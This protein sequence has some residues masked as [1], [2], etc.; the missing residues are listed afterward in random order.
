VDWLPARFAWV[1]AALSF[2]T[3][4][5]SLWSALAGHQKRATD[6]ADLHFRWN[7]LA[8]RY[9]ELWDEMYDPKA[10]T[11]LRQ[12]KGIAAEISKSDAAFPNDAERMGKWQTL[13][14]AQHQTA[15]TA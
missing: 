1:R 12:L 6:C 2:V 10:A 15:R 3:A 14:E 4:G 7:T 5:L 9:A 8:T 13:V 11:T